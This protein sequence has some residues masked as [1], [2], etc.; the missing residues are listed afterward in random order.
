MEAIF[1]KEIMRSKF[2]E[3]FNN[4]LVGQEMLFKA[5]Y[6]LRHWKFYCMAEL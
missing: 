3:V 6:Y 1:G 5:I 2:I 4:V